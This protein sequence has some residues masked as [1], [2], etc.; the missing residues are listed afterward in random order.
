MERV[1]LLHMIVRQLDVLQRHVFGERR[2]VLDLIVR[3]V[4]V[5][6]LAHSLERR[7]VFNLV[8]RQ[9]ER[10]KVRAFFKAGQIG[11]LHADALDGGKIDHVRFDN[12]FVVVAL[13][14]DELA[15]G[16]L[17]NFIFEHGRF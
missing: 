8:L 10:R 1:Q 13:V 12:R 9:I 4:Q 17:Q 11:D 2:D 14:E 6:Q 5:L 15:H 16:F 3:Q 7:Q